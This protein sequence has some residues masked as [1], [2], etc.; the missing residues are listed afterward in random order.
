MK[1]RW[2][3]EDLFGSVTAS[4]EISMGED[5]VEVSSKVV[6]RDISAIA[7]EVD[8]FFAD[9]TTYVAGA[10][11]EHAPAEITPKI[12]HAEATLKAN[13]NETAPYEVAPEARTEV[14]PSSLS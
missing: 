12:T 13:P 11:T 9:Q 8:A 1:A 4:G 10:S 2:E 3:E 6:P 5:G 14:A 7:T